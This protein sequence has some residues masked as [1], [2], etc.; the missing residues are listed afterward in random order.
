MG[1]LLSTW[2]A[3][4]I[5]SVA[6]LVALALGMLAV[7]YT[8]VFGAKRIDVK[9]ERSLTAAAVVRIAGVG[10]GTNVFHLDP[11]A[12]ETRLR[13]S[14]W[15]AEAT[16]ER[17]LPSTILI[18]IVEREPVARASIGGRMRIVAGDG[19]VLPGG[20]ASDLPQVRAPVG[21]LQMQAWTSGTRALAAMT[22]SVRARVGAVVVGMDGALTLDVDGGI[23]VAY[24]PPGDD[25]A[26]AAALHA[27]LA[28]ASGGDVE[29][30]T[31]DLT[32]PDA[33]TATTTGGVAVAP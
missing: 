3:R 27:I 22:P 2:R 8:P 11:A 10:E 30:A 16:V 13:S 25:D 17:D 21:E 31:I 18:R 24:G 6:A 28:W 19:T 15:V 23:E 20:D 29:L 26:K 1:E 12:V 33:P 5:V 14:P 9:G 4:L 32:V 7:T